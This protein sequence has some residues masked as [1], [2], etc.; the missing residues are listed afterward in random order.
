[1]GNF[2]IILPAKH[3]FLTASNKHALFIVKAEGQIN[4]NFDNFLFGKTCTIESN[5]SLFLNF[6]R[7]MNKLS[8]VFS[9]LIMK[10][11]NL[12]HEKNLENIICKITK[13]YSKMKIHIENINTKVDNLMQL[14]IYHFKN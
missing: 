3:L 13:C 6:W 14:C 1:M 10:T 4:K 9:F 8:D 11:F 2:L 7:L 12:L 5:Q